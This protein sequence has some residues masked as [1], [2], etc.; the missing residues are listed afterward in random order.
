MEVRPIEF[1]ES[2]ARVPV[3]QVRQQHVLQ[4]EPDLARDQ[5]ARLNAD[6]HLLDLNRPVE[7]TETESHVVLPDKERSFEQ[8]PKRDGQSEGEERPSQ[9]KR[10]PPIGQNI[11]L[12]V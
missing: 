11:D 8:S 4:R 3:E 6:G 9:D 12:I 5:S 1:Q 2:F 10:T 7:T